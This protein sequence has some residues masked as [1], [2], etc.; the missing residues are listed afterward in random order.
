[1]DAITTA[2]GGGAARAP[3]GA[4]SAR[5]PRRLA[6]A[7]AALER[8]AD[9]GAE[10]LAAGAGPARG[11]DWAD[12]AQS[13]LADVAARLAELGRCARAGALAAAL[14]GALDGERAWCAAALAEALAAAEGAQGVERLHALGRAAALAEA[15]EPL[16]RLARAAGAGR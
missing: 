8:W 1:M 3:A 6:R 4:S 16:A 14:G 5:R 10:A 7:I 13:G 2:E 12:G 11:E 15:A 9:R